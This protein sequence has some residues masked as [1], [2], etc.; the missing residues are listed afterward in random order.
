MDTKTKIQKI[1]SKGQVTLPAAWRKAVGTDH[2]IVRT[3]GNTLE[4]RP[5]HIPPPEPDEVTIFDAWRDNN[6]EGLSPEQIR[7]MLLK[8]QSK[9][10]R[11]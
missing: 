1:S 11:D 4:I 10:E 9:H 8:L 2:I 3:N 6:G 7:D 5:M